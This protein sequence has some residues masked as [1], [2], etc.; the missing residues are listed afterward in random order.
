MS[1]R[2]VFSPFIESIYFQHQLF[3]VFAPPG[4]QLLK[5]SPV[6][7]PDHAGASAHRLL[8]GI[9]KTGH[10][11]GD[12]DQVLSFPTLTTLAHIVTQG[13]MPSVSQVRSRPGHPWW[14]ISNATCF[15]LPPDMTSCLLWEGGPLH[16]W[17]CLAHTWQ[18]RP[19]AAL[20]A[21]PRSPHAFWTLSTL[22]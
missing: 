2:P 7:N 9:L 4:Y 3:Q 21:P 13:G 15:A 11:T 5:G 6:S 18:R 20:P 1:P 19:R 14:S 17:H 16:S 10:E 8:S 22:G 12:L